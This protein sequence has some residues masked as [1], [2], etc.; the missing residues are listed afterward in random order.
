MVLFHRLVMSLF[1]WVHGRRHYRLTTD[2]QL[3]CKETSAPPK[4]APQAAEF[5]RM[6]FWFWG[7]SLDRDPSLP[8]R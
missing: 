5:L 7:I 1:R 3:T 2:H 4:Y 6:F 8:R